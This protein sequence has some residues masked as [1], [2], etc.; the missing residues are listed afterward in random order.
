M[1]LPLI[2]NTSLTFGAGQPHSCC[3]K[4][5]SCC[6]FRSILAAALRQTQGYRKLFARLSCDLRETNSRK[7]GSSPSL[8][9]CA[10]YANCE[11]IVRLP[12]NCLATWKHRPKIVKKM[13]TLKILRMTWQ[14]P[15]GLANRK[16]FLQRSHET[17]QKCCRRQVYGCRMI[18][19]KLA[20][21][22]IFDFTT[23]GDWDCVAAVERPPAL[24]YSVDFIFL[25]F[26]I[27]GFIVE[28]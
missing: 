23:A 20:L 2:G 14:Q 26:G 25:S 7:I 9:S 28:L 13:N 18:D 11:D 15:W 21:Y 4:F 5:C 24:H 17:L 27:M 12:C 22:N 8:T 3:A 6:T 10:P 19:V 1:D 16:M